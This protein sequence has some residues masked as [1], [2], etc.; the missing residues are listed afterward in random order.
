MRAEFITVPEAA[1][2]ADVDDRAVNRAIDEKILPDELVENRDGRRIAELGAGLF[3]FYVEAEDK[4]TA[5]LRRTVIQ[6]ISGNLLRRFR[7][8]AVSFK[9]DEFFAAADV[10]RVVANEL[11]VIDLRPLLQKTATRARKV[12]AALD[13]ITTD[14][15][16]LG[17]TPVFRGTRVPIDP[18]LA[19][20]DAGIPFERIQRSY[21]SLTPELVEF[22][23]IYAKVRPRRGRPP[24]LSEK[25]GVAPA[26]R[27]L[28][29]PRKR[30]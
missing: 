27:K 13:A 18:V 28:V 11:V 10:F 24:S 20:I 21:S 15:D 9:D 29:R 25:L 30:M 14:E 7:A 2:I 6:T 16:V 17:G 8:V 19:S 12:R 23:R 22:A 3:R 4:L 26:E 5:Q 1:F